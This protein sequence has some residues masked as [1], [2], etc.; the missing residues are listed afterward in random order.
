MKKQNPKI[1]LI[2]QL[3][4]IVLIL[5]FTLLTWFKNEEKSNSK[6]T[7][8]APPSAS[9]W[10][11]YDT[12]MSE[13]RFGQN[14]IPFDYYTLALSWSPAFCDTQREKHGKLPASSRYQCQN[15]FGWVIH[16]LWP[17]SA[18]AKQPA[19]H[20]RFCQGDLAPLP[21]KAIQP[22]LGSSPSAALL[23]GQWEKHGAC[24]FNSAEAYF[25]K[26][27]ALFDALTLPT[28]EMSRSALFKW[29]K[30]HNPP[31][32]DVYLGASKSELYLCYNKS[33]SLIDCPR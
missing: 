20:P 33:W 12:V 10:G 4:F 30:Q 22:Y 11:D 16:G 28:E 8:S 2:S 7:P 13:D 25:A 29:L 1:R 21:A 32:R 14:R 5:I 31:L 19:D 27:Q 15:D 9:E 18:K 24:A 26:Q 17:Q 6:S 3:I 23:Q